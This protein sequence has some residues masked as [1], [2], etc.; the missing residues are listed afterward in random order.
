MIEAAI[1][2]CGSPEHL[3]SD[4]GPEFIA[5]AIQDCL[6]NA[7]KT[8]I[9]PGSPSGD[10]HIENLRDKLRDECLNN[11]VTENVPCPRDPRAAPE[12]GGPDTRVGAIAVQ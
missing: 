7:I 11:I 2:R 9:R 1:A 3:P 6:K 10:A 5:Y 4:N 12:A 8:Y